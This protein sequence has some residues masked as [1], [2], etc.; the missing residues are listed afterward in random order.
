MSDRKP[1]YV[2]SVG[3]L[4]FVLSSPQILLAVAMGWFAYA[5]R[6]WPIPAT[7]GIHPPTRFFSDFNHQSFWQD[8]FIS[9]RWK[10]K[11]N[12]IYDCSVK[13]FNPETGELHPLDLRLS[14]QSGFKQFAAGDRIWFVAIAGE[15]TYEVVDGRLLKTSFV[16]PSNSW[17]NGEPFLWNGDPAYIDSTRQGFVISTFQNGTWSHR[18][19][20]ALPDFSRERLLNGVPIRPNLGKATVQVIVTTEGTHLFLHAD[21]LVLH[22]KGLEV[23]Q[24][25]SISPS[26]SADLVEAVSKQSEVKTVAFNDDVDT[27][28]KNAHSNADLE[29]WTLVRQQPSKPDFG[30]RCTQGLLIDGLPAALVVE[31]I[32]AGCPTARCY[33]FEGV[34]WN[35]FSVQPLVFGARSFRVVITQD[36]LRSYLV[37]MTSTGTAHFYAVEATGLRKTNARDSGENNGLVQLVVYLTVLVVTVGLGLLMGIGTWCLMWWFTKPNYEFGVQ[38]VKLASLGRRGIAR[39]IDLGLTCFIVVGFGWLMTRDLDWLSLVEA[40]NLRVDHPV[41][42]QA[43]RVVMLLA[44]WFAGTIFTMLATQAVWGITPGKWLCRLRTV[45]TSLRPCGFAASLAREIVF[46]VDCCNFLC[47]A[48]GILSIALT[49]RRQ[50]LGDFVADTIV[51]ET[52]RVASCYLRSF[53]IFSKTK[54]SS[55]TD[56]TQNKHGFLKRI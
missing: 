40:V 4:A 1:G 21:G 31:D 18:G 27:P 32:S 36:R 53:H 55:A 52:P 37:A 29:G 9:I 6:T 44:T 3:L 19:S 43:L 23:N 42:S 5:Y 10:Q 33:R 12:G 22:R 41:V 47:W 35:E 50:R 51:I 20:L 8:G 49:D 7:V 48:P 2:I 56:E 14:G 30:N 26:P 34:A 45:R 11:A 15:D 46:C 28:Q 24:P 13:S 39:L 17:T 38:S 25:G 54:K 16:M